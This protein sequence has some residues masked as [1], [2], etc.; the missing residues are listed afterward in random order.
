[1]VRSAKRGASKLYCSDRTFLVDIVMPAAG[2][3]GARADSS[4]LC[5]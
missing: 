5:S 2:G 4:L 3:R 1:L